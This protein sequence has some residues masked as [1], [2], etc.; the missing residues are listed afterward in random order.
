MEKEQLLK[1]D[2]MTEISFQAMGAAQLVLL[3]LDIHVLMIIHNLFTLLE[4]KF[5]EMVEIMEVSNV[6]M[7]IKMIMM[8]V[9]QIVILSLALFAHKV[10]Q[11]IEIYVQK[12]VG[13]Q[14]IMDSITVR[15]VTC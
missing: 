11:L 8:A 10:R 15:M 14:R 3:N 12:F 6:M 7:E 1:K 13:M 5:V 4:V 9:T 2:V